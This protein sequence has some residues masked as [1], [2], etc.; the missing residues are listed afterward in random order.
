[1]RVLFLVVFCISKI[2]LADSSVLL[3]NAFGDQCY[4][5]G[6]HSIQSNR[7]AHDLRAAI[8]AVRSDRVRC[9]GVVSAFDAFQNSVQA[10]NGMDR[11]SYIASLEG[12][13]QDLSAALLQEKQLGASA[14]ASYIIELQRS[15]S[16]HRLDLINA[17]QSQDI[18]QRPVQIAALQN[19]Y[20][21][22]RGLMNAIQQNGPCIEGHPALAGQVGAQ[23]VSLAGNFSSSLVAG[24][25]VAGASLINQL[26][27]FLSNR[28]LDKELRNLADSSR[29][30]A[31]GC[32]IE[33]V[34]RSF[35]QAR[36]YIS[37]VQAE[38]TGTVCD[39]C[40]K[41]EKGLQ[42]LR[43]ELEAYSEWVRRLSAG[44]PAATQGQASDRNQAN[45][46]Q[47]KSDSFNNTIDAIL[48]EGARDI[49]ESSDKMLARQALASSISSAIAAASVQS[50]S[51]GA[52]GCTL[53]TGF[54][55]RLFP[56]DPT[57]GPFA[58]V[59]SQGTSRTCPKTPG[60]ECSQCILRSFPTIPDTDQMR[61]VVDKIKL[62]GQR[63]VARLRQRYIETNPLAAI[64]EAD[65]RGANNKSARDFLVN[66]KA[67]FE[68][69]LGDPESAT[70]LP[71]A[72]KQEVTEA[73][74]RIDRALAILNKSTGFTSSD[75]SSLSQELIPANTLFFISDTL[76]RLV[77]REYA[78]SL[79][80]ASGVN[81]AVAA[82][83]QFSVRETVGQL[84][85]QYRNP[86]Q[87]EAQ[88]ETA[89]AQSL[90]TLGS[91]S[92]VFGSQLEAAITELA[93]SGRSPTLLAV[94][95][96]RYA[97]LTSQ[98]PKS[99]GRAC[100]KTALS[101]GRGTSAPFT[102]KF[103]DVVK[104]PQ[105]TRLCSIYDFSRKEQVLRRSS[106]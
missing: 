1:M 42:V 60:E 43:T 58:F 59:Y 33:G 38:T 75:V 72:L 73:R 87:A 94:N 68:S 22:S 79:S 82:M 70:A 97:A 8:E 92:Q 14:D 45:L 20:S 90:S 21:Y 100:E 47:E 54:L 81:P 27:T 19:I 10:Y 91:I 98:V 101:G 84:L 34:S 89:Q 63:E 62:E 4:S 96:L 46:L 18:S 48:S 29:T 11:A 105:N 106:K 36:D 78:K 41:Q 50:Q 99:V 64:S 7:Q 88:A 12:N 30:N 9:S 104:S 23:L 55:G 52:T 61:T 24:G 32:A 76:N 83:V 5:I 93:A 37:I 17:R 57:C 25:I 26:I 49:E 86:T 103:T 69:R 3:M 80:Q 53:S 31:I 56:T 71:G 39:S 6:E 15:L 13:I 102:V 16:D 51:C 67:Y 77:Q 2:A 28:G 85:A 95:C 40:E 35:C 66:S 65:T 74:D 44:S